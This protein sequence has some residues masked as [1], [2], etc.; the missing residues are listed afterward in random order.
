MLYYVI[1]SLRTSYKRT[2]FNQFSTDGS[3]KPDL[4]TDFHPDLYDPRNER[5]WLIR[6]EDF[7]TD[8]EKATLFFDK[9]RRGRIMVSDLPEKL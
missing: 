5:A 2:Y 6:Q 3:F 9:L 8:L 4:I 7:L 1:G